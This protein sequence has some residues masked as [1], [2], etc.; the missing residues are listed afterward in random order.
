MIR[1]LLLVELLCLPF[2]MLSHFLV[3]TCPDDL[4]RWQEHVTFFYFER[5]TDQM[6]VE[7]H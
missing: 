6:E 2:Y 4:S 7:S 3:R 1:W 5:E